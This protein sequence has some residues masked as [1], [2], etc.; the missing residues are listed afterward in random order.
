[1]VEIVLFVENVEN[2]VVS[3]YEK[4]WLNSVRHAGLDPASSSVK[5]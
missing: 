5:C 4:K 3:E 1:M 2:E